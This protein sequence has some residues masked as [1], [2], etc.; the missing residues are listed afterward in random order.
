[1]LDETNLV[2]TSPTKIKKKVGETKGAKITCRIAI[3]SGF[4]IFHGN[5]KHFTAYI[6]RK[7]GYAPGGTI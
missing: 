3:H 2:N 4:L 6:M 7:R 5:I 1:M